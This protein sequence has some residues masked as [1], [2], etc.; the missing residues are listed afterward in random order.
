MLQ[1]KAIVIQDLNNLFIHILRLKILL[2]LGNSDIQGSEEESVI[3]KLFTNNRR[4]GF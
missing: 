3:I 4:T 2:L 1:K